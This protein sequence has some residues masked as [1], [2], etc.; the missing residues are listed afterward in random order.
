MRA[1]FFA[2]QLSFEPVVRFWMLLE[3][4]VCHQNR[5]G[6]ASLVIRSPCSADADGSIADKFHDRKRQERQLVDKKAKESLE[7]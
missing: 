2:G 3:L 6:P 1:Q 5:A 7:E 4:Q